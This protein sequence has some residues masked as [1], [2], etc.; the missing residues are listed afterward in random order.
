MANVEKRDAGRR[1]ARW[2]ILFI[3][4]ASLTGCGG[5][6]RSLQPNGRCTRSF[7]DD[8]KHV[9]QANGDLSRER[10]HAAL[11]RLGGACALFFSRHEGAACRAIVNGKEDWVYAG[12]LKLRCDHARRLLRQ[13]SS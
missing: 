9:L 6:S 2:I 3:C 13:K 10:S 5:S 1:T 4:T 11:A 12:D 7:V 8:F